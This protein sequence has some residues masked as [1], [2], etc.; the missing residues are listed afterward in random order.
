MT[1][2]IATVITLLFLIPFGWAVYLLAADRAIDAARQQAVALAPA[3][4]VG[5]DRQS[6][7]RAIGKE[8]DWSERI[9]V[10]QPGAL[11]VGDVRAQAAAGAM[12]TD[13]VDERTVPVPGGDVY[14]Q[15]VTATNGRTSVTEVF[16][17]NADLYGAVLLQWLGLGAL[18]V[19]A[20][21]ASVLIADRVAL[22]LVIAARALDRAAGEFAADLTRR[23]DVTGPAELADA[24][25]A[26]NGMADRVVTLLRAEREL[27]ADLS[28]R[29]RTPL[30]ALRLDAEAIPPGPVAQ[31][32]REA[33]DA[34]ETEV[35]A[36]IH[37][38]RAPI[39][40]RKAEQNDLVDVL[41]DRLAFWA[42]LAED[43]RRPWQ[44]T[45]AE[46]PLWLPIPRDDL[47][48]TVDALLGNVFEHTPQGTAFAVH[49]LPDRLVVEDAGPGISDVAS[50]LRRGESGSGSTGLGLSI[51]VRVAEMI[52]GAIRID[53]G[54]LGGARIALILPVAA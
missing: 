41:A 24:A 34:L 43:H 50:A 44:V 26:F 47:I 1:A 2:A 51:V 48:G 13:G 27:A 12:L 35:D 28:H 7:Q 49:V 15:A 19:L 23:A 9:A 31:R 30:T 14:L 21:A 16:V 36:I 52:G 53:R 39:G 10:Y 11:P 29:L 37:D 32:I 5:A 25:A 40:D 46:T 22:R 45:G 3:V 42:V 17:P 33:V 4:A 38:A 20:I 18:G 6:L 8:P 54:D